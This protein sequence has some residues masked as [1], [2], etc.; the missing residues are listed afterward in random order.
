MPE[1]YLMTEPTTIEDK[2][3]KAVLLASQKSVADGIA[4]KRVADVKAAKA[5]REG[6][7]KIVKPTTKGLGTVNLT[8]KRLA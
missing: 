6:T 3:R 1:D 5:K 2:R 4:D 8:V 7:D